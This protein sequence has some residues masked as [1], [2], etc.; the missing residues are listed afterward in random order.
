M[1]NINIKLHSQTQNNI[2]GQKFV[3]GIMHM[4]GYGLGFRLGCG[5]GYVYGLGYA[6]WVRVLFRDY[7]VS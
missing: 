2:C 7:G 3:S 1:S 6:L 4:L 5:L